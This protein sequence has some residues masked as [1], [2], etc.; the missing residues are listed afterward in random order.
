MR[1]EWITSICTLLSLSNTNTPS[2]NDR[3]KIWMKKEMYYHNCIAWYFV[4]MCVFQ[5]EIL[6]L[7]FCLPRG[8]WEILIFRRWGYNAG[9]KHKSRTVQGVY[10]IDCTVS[11]I[12]RW[13]LR[14]YIT[15]CSTSLYAQ[16]K[17]M[18]RKRPSS[19]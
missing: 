15:P 17:K 6:L 12:Y 1:T 18:K 10:S 5:L 13:V 19:T 8:T 7:L 11:P 14:S 16:N 2:N 9:R 4:F 3:R